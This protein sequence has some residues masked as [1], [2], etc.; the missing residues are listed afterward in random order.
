M[1][2]GYLYEL[3]IGRKIRKYR[4]VSA[5]PT[6]QALSD[7]AY[8]ASNGDDFRLCMKVGADLN[9]LV[10]GQTALMRAVSASHRES[11]HMILSDHPDLEVRAEEVP[12][13]IEGD[14]IVPGDTVLIAACRQG[15]WDMVRSL[16]AKG[17][18][19]DAV[20]GDGKK[21][22]EVAC[23][24]A[25]RQLDP[26]NKPGRRYYDPQNGNPAVRSAVSDALKDL[27]TKTS[28]LADLVINA[29]HHCDDESLVHFF[30]W[31]E[32]EELLLL[33]L[34]GG[35]DIDEGDGDGRTALMRVADRARPR[36]VQL[37]IDNG[38]DVHL[39]DDLGRT[40]LY[41]AVP[42]PGDSCDE[43]Y[44][45]RIRGE[46]FIS[47]VRTILEIL[48]HHGV[49]V[50]GQEGPSESILHRAVDWG[51]PEMVTFFVDTGADLEVEDRHGD[52]PYDLAVKLKRAPEIVARLAVRKPW[53]W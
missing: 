41:F 33:S 16:V 50:N 5:E 21:A 7:F 24:E 48:L 34:A 53:D 52:T 20:G 11:F 14:Y 30:A 10:E 22:L 44:L 25:E 9:G 6:Q 40:V 26:K 28:D 2:V 8:G 13:F 15:R 23:E 51:V 49:D 38:A 37:L 45:S 43:I 17:A 32:F 46:S 36:Y 42:K 27:L 3:G 4:P 19:V 12:F 29:R 31:H 35:V 39:E 18:N 1:D 47:S